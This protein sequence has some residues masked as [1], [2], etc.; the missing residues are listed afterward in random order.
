MKLILS[1]CDFRNDHAKKTIIDNLPK[2]ISQCKLLYIPNEKATFD[3]IHSDR[4]YFRMEEFGFTRENVYVFDY[5][6]TEAFRG[7]DIDILYISGGNTFAIMDRLRKGNFENEI[8][9]YVKNGVIYIGGSAGAH[10]ASQNIEHVAEF[11]PI[12]D[13]MTDFH[14]LGLFDG[15]LIC[16]YTEDRSALYE[17]LKAEG[18]YKV[19]ALGNDDSLVIHSDKDSVMKQ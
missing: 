7:L 4:Y 3:T 8:I 19:F 15:I 14:G 5:D 6:N 11:D 2:P 17:K 13:G 9:R 16:H 1:S 12:P 10:I 18:T